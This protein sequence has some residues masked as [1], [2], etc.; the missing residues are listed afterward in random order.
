MV[1]GRLFGVGPELDAFNA[2][3]NLPDLLRA[4]ITG[5]ALSI[6]LIPVL[7]E[8]LERAGREALWNVF[9][10]VANLAFLVTGV[11]AV[12]VG[13]FSDDIVRAE[14]GIAPGFDPELQ[15]LVADLMR[16]NLLALLIF[17][18]SGLA[19]AGLQA[20]QHFLLPAMAPVLYDL[21]QLFGAVVLAPERGDRVLGVGLPGMGLGVHGLMYGVLLGALLHLA[22]QL[23]GLVRHRFRWSPRFGLTHPDVVKVLRLMGPRV[24]TIGA[25]Q[26]I[27]VMQDNLASRLDVGSVTA[28]TFGWLIMQVPETMFGTAVG[29]ALLPTLG[30]LFARRADGEFHDRIAR[31]LRAILALTLP[32]AALLMVAIRPLVAAVFGFDDRGTELVA[33]ATRA[34]LVGLVGHALLE[35]LARAFYARQN[36]L[37]PLAARAVNMIAF[38]A[39]GVVLFRR[40]GAAGIALSN[41]LGFTLEAAVLL[42]LLARSAPGLVRPQRAAARIL[43]GSVL[44]GGAAWGLMALAP[45]APFLTGLL[46]LALGGLIALPFVTPELRLLL[47][48]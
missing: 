3:N 47:R 39:L 44:A 12:I 33:W 38:A 10:R 25:F 8:T 28:L 9:T 7:S 22:V 43:F 40:L 4:L 29:T 24:L 1:I 6:A 34:Y 5:G 37:I 15:M 11:V 46:A 13:V 42:V 32:T 45:L 30:E 14:F 23:P 35:V 19:T 48:L 36:A 17:S 21:G 18:L 26:A 2:A 41:S 20:N 31:A 27:F 16:W